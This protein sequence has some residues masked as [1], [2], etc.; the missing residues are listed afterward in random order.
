MQQFSYWQAIIRSFYSKALYQDV[1]KNWRGISVRYLMLICFICSLPLLYVIQGTV[2]RIANDLYAIAAQV[3][4]I[5]I[6]NG[7]ASINKPEP[8]E[9][10]EPETN[11]TIM[12]IDTSA[13]PD[14]STENKNLFVVLN[15][16]KVIINPGKNSTKTYELTDIENIVI[17]E[18]RVT[19]WVKFLIIAM[20]I[21]FY[22]STYLFLFIPS[23]LIAL[24]YGVIAKLFVR[25]YHSYSEL[26]RLAVVALTPTL[27]LIAMLTAL[28]I[29]LPYRNIIYLMLSLGYLT[30]AIE[31]NRPHKEP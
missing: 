3:P 23:L 2:S 25:S 17:D 13:K 24:F 31:A 21:S 5:T 22:L 20:F 12:V 16:N 29:A 26:T 28:N 10:K 4:V 30:F 15:K 14:N 11:K 9:I 18:A 27:I 6:K 1:D 7:E 8:Y 19:Y